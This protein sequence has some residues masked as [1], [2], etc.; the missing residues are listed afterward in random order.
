MITRLT[1]FVNKVEMQ[2]ISCTRQIKNLA[3]GTN[4]SIGPRSAADLYAHLLSKYT[5]GTTLYIFLNSTHV[6]VSDRE[7]SYVFC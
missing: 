2:G 6:Y 5:S 4:K 3:S 1:C 7:E